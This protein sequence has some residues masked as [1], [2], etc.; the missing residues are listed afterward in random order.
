MSRPKLKLSAAE[1]PSLPPGKHALG[2]LSIYLEVRPGGTRSWTCRLYRDGRERWAG[3]G[4]WPEVGITKA[5]ELAQALRDQQREGIDPIEARKQARRQDAA[6]AM[7][8]SMACDAYRAAHQAAWRPNYR[9]AVFSLHKL[10]AAGLGSRPIGTLDT[11]QV[12]AFLEPLWGRVPSRARKCQSLL[13]L[14]VEFSAARGWFDPDKQNPAA[15]SRLQHLL[16]KRPKG[17]RRRLRAIDYAEAPALWQALEGR[18]G[19]AVEALRLVM[20]T[21]CRVGEITGASWSEISF[22]EATLTVPASRMKAGIEHVVPLTPPALDA[23]RRM[24]AVRRGKLIFPSSADARKSL[25]TMAL[26]ALLDRVG[27]RE[28]TTVHGLRSALRSWL[29]DQAV[30]HELAE[31]IL[32]HS[33]GPVVSAYQRS[34]MTERKREALL[35]WAEFLTT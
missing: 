22:T 15:W 26:L 21:G 11:E 24:E 19:A 6:D 5:R 25:T 20:L 16:A 14:L 27:W 32:A 12:R 23:L 18:K 30:P 34:A 10:I 28:R 7:T 33:P 4:P 31:A 1:I 3:I 2:D 8:V 17:A 29:A 13:A 35:R 9:K